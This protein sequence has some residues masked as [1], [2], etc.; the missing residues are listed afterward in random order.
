VPR[1]GVGIVQGLETLEAPHAVDGLETYRGHQPRA[2]VCRHA[3]SRPLLQ[4]RPER[5]VHGLFG[6]VEISQQADQRGEH[7]AGVGEVDGVHR[8]VYW[9]GRRHS[10]RSHHVD[11]ASARPPDF[12]VLITFLIAGRTATGRIDRSTTSFF[13]VE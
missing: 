4:R 2:R 8:L 12:H 11:S 13:V 9:I 6:A 1:L 7:A 3:V 5:V 10:D